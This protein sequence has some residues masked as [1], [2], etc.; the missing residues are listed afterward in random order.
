[1]NGF[2]ALRGAYRNP[3]SSEEER[4]V[5][6]NTKPT[7]NTERLSQRHSC[8]HARSTEIHGTWIVTADDFL[9]PR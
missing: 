2:E 1:M 4:M 9:I 3:L 8:F 5:I 7:I 6:L